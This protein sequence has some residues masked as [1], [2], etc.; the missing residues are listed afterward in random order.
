MIL[1]AASCAHFQCRHLCLSP[2]P[3]SSLLARG[4]PWQTWR[5]GPW[6]RGAGRGTGNLRASE[7]TLRARSAGVYVLV[8]PER[9]MCVPAAVTCCLCQPQGRRRLGC[10][11]LCVPGVLCVGAAES[12]ALSVVVC[13]TGCIRVLPGCPWHRCS[14]SLQVE[15]AKGK[16]AAVSLSLGRQIGTLGTGLAFSGRAGPYWVCTILLVCTGLQSIWG[17]QQDLVKLCV[18]LRL[19]VH[20]AYIMMGD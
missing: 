11:C 3:P 12:G 7:R 4:A 6:G 15:P 1:I 20:N 17:S 19:C 14:A 8:N 13:V 9:A 5:G 16:V 18:C 10:L 2:C